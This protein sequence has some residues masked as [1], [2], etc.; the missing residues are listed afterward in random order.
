MTKRK[1]RE[2]ALA[3]TMTKLS[4]KDIRKALEKYRA[5]NILRNKLEVVVNQ[6]TLLW[7]SINGLTTKTMDEEGTPEKVIDE[8]QEKSNDEKQQGDP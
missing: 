1:I 4:K 6:S 5:F 7:K 3:Q 8:T 2:V